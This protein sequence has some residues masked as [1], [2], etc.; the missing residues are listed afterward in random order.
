PGDT[1]DTGDIFAEDLCLAGFDV[2]A[3][4]DAIRALELDMFLTGAYAGEWE[5]AGLILAHRLA[6]V[7]IWPGAVCPTTGGFRS[8]DHVLSARATE[9][10]DP[11]RHYMQPLSWIDGPLQAAYAFPVPARTG[12]A[13][14]RR[15]LSLGRG[16]VML[17]SGAMAH[18]VTDT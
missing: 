14:L 16:R 8:F 3:S 11:Q 12:T 7:Q 6:P 15:A 1:L 10:D 9:P 17:T 18:K 2:F 13:A 4:V 5:K